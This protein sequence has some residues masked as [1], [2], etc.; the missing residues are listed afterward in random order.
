MKNISLILSILFLISCEKEPVV[1]TLSVLSNPP[2]GGIVSPVSQ[3]YNS[4]ETATISATPSSEFI[5]ENW[6][7]SVSGTSPTIT[8]TMDSDK[9]VQANFVKKKYE[10]TID[11][12]G[13]GQVNEEII[14]PGITDNSEHNS[15]TILRLTA[16]GDQGWNFKE[17][18]GDVS[19]NDNVI[20]IT[21]DSPKNLIVVFSTS[22]EGSI[23]KGPYLSGTNVDMYELNNDLSQTGKNFT[24]TI[25]NNKSGYT[26]DE[27]PLNGNY[28][29]LKGLG[30]YYNEVLS[31]N[32][33]SQLSLSAL[34]E[35]GNNGLANINIITS[36]ERERVEFLVANGSDFGNAK[37]QALSEILNNFEI[38]ENISQT[39]EYLNLS[40][41]GEGNAI[42]LAISSIVQGYRSD[43]E[44]NE[45]ISDISNDLKEDGTIDNEIIGSKLLSQADYLMPQKI[46]NNLVGKYQ[47]MGENIQLT[48]FEP[49]L[50][51][52]T[53]NSSFPR[54]HS[55]YKY[56]QYNND[57]MLNILNKDFVSMKGLFDFQNHAIGTYGNLAMVANIDIDGG[58]KIKITT[59]TGRVQHLLSDGSAFVPNNSFYNFDTDI[60]EVVYEVDE[61][62]AGIEAQKILYFN[63]PGIYI[64]DYY[65]LGSE[66]PTFSKTVNI[67]YDLENDYTYVPDYRF[68]LKFDLE[69]AYSPKTKYQRDNYVHTEK[70]LSIKDLEIFDI[71]TSIFTIDE[72]IQIE[73]FTGLEVMTNL[74]SLKLNDNN[75]VKKIN[76][77]TLTKLTTFDASECDNLTCIIV[78]QDQLDNIPSGWKKPDNAQY[79]LS[80]D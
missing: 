62:S 53:D 60:L 12:E 32:S 79:K 77:S 74:E 34:H 26:F 6:T 31:K 40:K 38:S 13:S 29:L 55:P 21:M 11:I 18:K 52:F 45:I 75:A 39:S 28:V 54:N 68:E 15:G 65:E 36:L 48:N 42:L 47:E 51:L 3:E 23:Q 33:T 43:A 7:G 76:L 17:W 14:Q 30:Y 46:S 16:V 69:F 24:M 8:L 19:G 20:E 37:K 57:N 22:I 70:L 80:C 59:Y 4:G 50:K 49:Y 63:T 64:I 1:Y 44:V 66:N 72:Y 9:S 5:F 73:D 41:E 35:I 78:S 61:N 67:D 56:P 25:N 58:L 2:E 10:L 71:N 27:V